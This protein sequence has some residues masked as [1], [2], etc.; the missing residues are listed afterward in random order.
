MKVMPLQDS[1]AAQYRYLFL[2]IVLLGDLLLYPYAGDG[3]L[4]YQWFRALGFGL[5]ALSV[6]AVS[7]RRW[8]L[9]IALLLAVPAA[10]NRIIVPRHDASVMALLG[11]MLTFAF[12]VFVLITIFRRIFRFERVTSST[13][14]GA[15][16]IYLLIGFSFTNLYTFVAKLQPWAF[17]LVPGVNIHQAVEYS[18]LIY[19]S[20]GSMTSL[21]SSGIIP[22]S[23]TVRSLAI[24]ESILGLLYLAVLVSRLVGMYHME[25]LIQKPAENSG[26]AETTD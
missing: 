7:F 2:F 4:R 14:F 20:F 15:L 17:Y 25:L 16:C 13:I 19:F 1:K 22:V 26:A 10:M 11:V 23:A 18:D 21:G 3:G 5:T 9:V 6:Y 8:T 12:D 24:V